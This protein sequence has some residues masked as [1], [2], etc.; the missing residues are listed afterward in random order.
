LFGK[1]IKKAISPIFQ[2]R[3]TLWA[4]ELASP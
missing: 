1:P 2:L 4:I 3:C